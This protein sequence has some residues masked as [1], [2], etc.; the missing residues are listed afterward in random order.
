VIAGGSG[1]VRNFN[2][3]IRRTFRHRGQRRSY[4]SARC[5]RG[6]FFARGMVLFRDGT[7]LAGTVVRPCRVS[8]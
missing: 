6:R 4:L 7:R 2:L 5:G 1:S 8:G 3:K